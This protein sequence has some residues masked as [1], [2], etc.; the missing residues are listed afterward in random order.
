VF[1][2]DGGTVFITVVQPDKVLKIDL[3]SMSVTGAADSG[4]EPDGVAFFGK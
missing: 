3:K 4:A 2:D 1:S